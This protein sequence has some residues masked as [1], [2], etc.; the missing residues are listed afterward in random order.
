MSR[1][2]WAKAAG[3]N[4]V[5]RISSGQSVM[6]ATRQLQTKA[7]SCSGWAVLIS[8]HRCSACGM[9]VSPSTSMR[10]RSY[11]RAPEHGEGFGVAE[12][13]VDVEIL[14]G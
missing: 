5:R 10:T 14:R 2:P 4:S 11:W 9:P 12:G 6:M 13:G 1:T 7:T 8:E 3:S